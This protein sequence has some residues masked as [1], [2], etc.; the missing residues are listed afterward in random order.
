MKKNEEKV[1]I[2]FKYFLDEWTPILSDCLIYLK[3]FYLYFFI[4]FIFI[5]SNK[6]NQKI[7]VF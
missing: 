1:Y 7:N 5:C 3:T 6:Y 4:K 2:F